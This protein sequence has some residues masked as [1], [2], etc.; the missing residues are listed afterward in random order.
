MTGPAAADFQKV[1]SAFPLL[2]ACFSRYIEWVLENDWAD[3]AKYDLLE[4]LVEADME[5]LAR[6][7]ESLQ[8]ARRILNLEVLPFARAFGFT[9]DLLAADPEKIHDVLAEPLYVLNL[10]ENAFTGIKKLPPALVENDTKL[11][12]ADF[13]AV[14]GSLTF[15]IELKTVRMETGVEN[16]NVMGDPFK[17]YW[18]GEMVRNNAVMKIEDKDR[19]VLSQ[20]ANTARL[21][22]CSH[23]M[24]TIYT[25]RLG[26][27]TLMSSADWT[28]ELEQLAAAYPQIDYFCIKDYFASV[29]FFPALAAI[30]A[31]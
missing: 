29:V 30:P 12:A 6:L 24:L 4:I 9:S 20:L 1:L 13:T 11:Q 10:D 3:A 25:R 22:R 19:R 8:Q 28:R 7:E 14:R 26:P 21:L 17:A 2:R 5:R 16:G 27:S 15:A 18:W 23:T 31:A